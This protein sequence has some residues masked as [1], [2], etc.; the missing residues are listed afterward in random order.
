MTD[1]RRIVYEALLMAEDKKMTDS[2]SKEVLDKYSYLGGSDRNFIKRLTEGVF[3]RRITIDYIIDA[4]SSTRTAKMKKQIRTLIRMGTYQ[5]V[6]MDGVADHAAVNETVKLSRKIGFSQ[7]SGFVNGVLRS[8]AKNKDD[9]KWPDRDKDVVSFL[10]VV[11]S[12]PDWIVKKLVKEAGEENATDLLKLSVSTRP[13]TARVNLSKGNV[14]EVLCEGYAE[15]SDLIDSAVILRDY[16]NI[17]DIGSFSNGLICI[18][19]ISS[20][21]V[22]IAAGIKSTDMVLD[23]CAAPGGKSLHA[24]DLAFEGRIISCDVSEKKTARITENAKRCHFENISV[25]TADATVYDDSFEEI[26]DVV[27]ADVPCSG[28][29]VMGRKNDIKFNLSEDSLETLMPLQRSILSNAARYV[30]PG[31]TLMFSTC[32]CSKEENAGNFRF[33][34]DEC[35]LTPVDFYGLLPERLRD[36]T[37][38]EGYIQLY[39]KDDLTDGFF[40]GKFTK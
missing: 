21:L 35:G 37:A 33:L 12:C 1:V 10:S 34:K 17:K 24:A 2:I 15:R 20:M 22:C 39:G 19:D 27:I 5:I 7:L 11:Y 16:D 26:A 9:I 6:Y 13:V 38:K 4:N 40:I 28:L 25:M 3:E 36:E 29:G 23:L 31:G 30:K 32:T 18:Q 8:I 14:D